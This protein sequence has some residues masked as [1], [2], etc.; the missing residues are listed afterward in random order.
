MIMKRFCTFQLTNFHTIPV[1]A[2]NKTD[3]IVIGAGLSGLNAALLLESGGMNVTVLE[4]RDRIGGRVQ[5]LR[6]IP[7][8]PEV[9]GTAFAP[10]YARLVD[11]ATKYGVGLIDITPTIPFFFD[12]QV[13]LK[14]QFISNAEW[15]ES[16]LNPFPDAFKKAPAYGYYNM[17]M[18]SINPLA[19]SDAWLK[20]E[21]AHLDI[22]LHEWLRQMGQSDAAIELAYNTNPTH[23]MSAHDISALMAMQAGYFGGMQRQLSATNPVKGYTAKGGN[24]AIPEAMANALKTEVR[25]NS[26]RLSR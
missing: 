26:A 7:G 2:L 3:V 10:G 22:S 6:N 4:G 23:G 12:R 8:N 15:P 21:N 24:Q 14:D 17:L 11:A 1:R 13:V 16:P 25:F 20:P 5:S 9:G 18:G 19:T